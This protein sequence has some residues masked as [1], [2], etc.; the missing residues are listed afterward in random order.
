MKY[1]AAAVSAPRGS[2][3]GAQSEVVVAD[4]LVLLT[5]FTASLTSEAGLFD[6]AERRGRVRGDAL[7]DAD[8][9]GGQLVGHVEGAVEG[10]GQGGRFGVGEGA[11]GAHLASWSAMTVSMAATSCR[12]SSSVVM[13]GG[14]ICTVLP[15]SGRV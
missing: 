3:G 6:P 8:Q 15:R 9:A 10:V 5:S 12:I 11:C 1:S 14:L 13:N 4:L 2:T 7:V